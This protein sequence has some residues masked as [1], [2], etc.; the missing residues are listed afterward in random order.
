MRM[1]SKD[2]FGRVGRGDGGSS[3]RGIA[4]GLRRQAPGRGASQKRGAG[5]GVEGGDGVEGG[6]RGC[7]RG[8]GVESGRGECVKGT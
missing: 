6:G 4:V 3:G 8:G 5:E 1:A 2:V 7:G